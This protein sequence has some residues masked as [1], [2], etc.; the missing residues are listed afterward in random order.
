MIGWSILSVGSVASEWEMSARPQC[1]VLL[2]SLLAI[3]I[4]CI[5]QLLN[6]FLV[7]LLFFIAHTGICIYICIRVNGA[8][9]FT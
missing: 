1:C 6:G 3:G 5:L 8:L 9:L 7:M 2:E 4:I